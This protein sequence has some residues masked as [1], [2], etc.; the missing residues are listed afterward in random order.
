MAALLSGFT[1]QE[2]SRW[3]GDLITLYN[4]LE[5][6]CS[7]VGVG[8]LSQVTS[9]RTRGKGLKLCQ[10][11]FRLHIRKNFFTKRLVECWNRLPSEVVESPF[12]EVFTRCVV[13]ALRDMV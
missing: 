8:L 10:G 13:M 1:K 2:I 5:G 9:D 3:S 6:G 11:T 7:Q 4:Y 12:L